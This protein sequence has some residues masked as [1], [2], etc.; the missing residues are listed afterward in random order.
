MLG[1]KP[2]AQDVTTFGRATF[3]AREVE[4]EGLG[5]IWVVR[6]VAWAA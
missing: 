6:V 1:F 4:V 2:D 5:M 3:R